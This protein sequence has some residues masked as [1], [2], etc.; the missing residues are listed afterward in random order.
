MQSMIPHLS[1]TSLDDIFNKS[2]V[3][4]RKN[5][6]DML[7][8]SMQSLAWGLG[9][10]P[11]FIAAT[12]IKMDVKETPSTFELSYEVPGCKKKDL[13]LEINGDCLV[14]SADRDVLKKEEGENFKRVERFYGRSTR[15]IN[16]P[17]S[18]S[19]K[20]IQNKSMYNITRI[21]II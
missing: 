13:K 17:S 3:W 16:V 8:Q 19:L 4:G 20:V 9:E 6:D 12:T 7:K 11:A 5:I 2:P 18:V 21:N 15:S 10:D 1:Q 14:L